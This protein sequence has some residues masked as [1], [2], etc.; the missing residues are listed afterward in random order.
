MRQLSVMKRESLPEEFIPYVRHVNQ[1]VI[2]LDSRCLMTVISIE[3]INFDT[4]D[5]QRIFL[6]FNIISSE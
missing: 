3:G 2:A 4:A 5:I 1:H 6:I